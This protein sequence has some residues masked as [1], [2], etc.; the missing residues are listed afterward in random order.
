MSAFTTTVNWSLSIGL[1]LAVAG[2]SLSSQAPRVSV[3]TV[4][5]T[6]GTYEHL[7]TNV[8]AQKLVTLLSSSSSM[9]N[10]NS[11]R[12]LSQVET[13]LDDYLQRLRVDTKTDSQL[14]PTAIELALFKTFYKQWLTDADAEGISGL[15][16][17]QSY[18]ASAGE[19]VYRILA[20]EYRIAQK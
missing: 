6:Y 18:A 15:K 2:C 8:D 4:T 19:L 12:S 14:R 11:Y 13:E 17:P 9:L 10:A 3:N 20:N 1:S 7:R 5:T 16:A